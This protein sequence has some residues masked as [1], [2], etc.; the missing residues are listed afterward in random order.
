M[1][2]GLLVVEV[3]VVASTGETLRPPPP[4]PALPHPSSRPFTSKSVRVADRVSFPPFPR[5]ETIGAAG[6]NPGL[7]VASTDRR[8]SRDQRRGEATETLN[9]SLDLGW[10]LVA[11]TDYLKVHVWLSPKRYLRS[12]RGPP[13]GA[14]PG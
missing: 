11:L 14:D 6:N 10:S 4:A 3:R 9:G 8:S 12:G 7:C 5:R 13:P 1:F 2:L